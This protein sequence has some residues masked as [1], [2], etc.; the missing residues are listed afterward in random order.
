MFKRTLELMAPYLPPI[1]FAYF[2]NVA[3]VLPPSNLDAW[4]E[5]FC[6]LRDFSD[7][8]LSRYS[9]V[10]Y[11]RHLL[12]TNIPDITAATTE[13]MARCGCAPLTN[14]TMDAE[15]AQAPEVD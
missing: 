14:Y 6:L 2:S 12:Q 10:H 7:I 15:D 13:L 11:T 4:T 3:S 8:H 9:A 5:L 1:D